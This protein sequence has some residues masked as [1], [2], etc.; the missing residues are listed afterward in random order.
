MKK[1]RGHDSEL[2]PPSMEDPTFTGESQACQDPV[3]FS[4]FIPNQK[5]LA[6][7]KNNYGEHQR[8]SLSETAMD[9]KQLTMTPKILHS[10]DDV[11]DSTR[12]SRRSLL[13]SSSP[14]A[15]QGYIF[16]QGNRILP[17]SGDQQ[18][19]RRKN[20][21]P[22]QS[23][24]A[25]EDVRPSSPRQGRF[26]AEQN[27]HGGHCPRYAFMAFFAAL[28][29]ASVAVVR[30]DMRERALTNYSQ[31]EF[32]QHSD[33]GILDD[34][35]S[36]QDAPAEPWTSVKA[37]ADSTF[38]GPARNGSSTIQWQDKDHDTS[39]K[40]EV[41]FSKEHTPLSLQQTTETA[42]TDTLEPSLRTD[43]TH[44]AATLPQAR[45]AA[46]VRPRG[47]S[48]PPRN[49][50]L[51]CQPYSQ[52]NTG[53]EPAVLHLLP[54][55][56]PSRVLLP[57]G[58]PHVHAG[59]RELRRGVQPLSQPV[60]LVPRLSEELPQ[61]RAPSARLLRE[62]PVFLVTRQ[63]VKARWWFFDGQRCRPWNFTAGLCPSPVDSSVF[64]SRV[65]ASVAVQCDATEALGCGRLGWGVAVCAKRPGEARPALPASSGSPSLRTSLLQVDVFAASGPLHPS[66]SRT[67]V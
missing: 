17:Y 3:G 63:D 11:F 12:R 50:F 43:P 22:H 40:L 36:K 31:S 55:V 66:C 14:H 35:G 15:S 49:L 8:T 5:F 27:Y 53:A 20:L 21:P 32:S 56:R 4:P 46:P 41:T 64:R 58:H 42:T 26:M 33:S 67:D 62:N 7:T 6:L 47:M 57:T 44:T 30:S 38:L 18:I 60:R 13:P 54:F 65:T 23:T 25:N 39:E 2:P 1:E 51:S 19:P 28:A 29:V 48:A 45:V 16:D 52:T 37:L 59:H 24:C 61:H 10:V 9:V 34:T